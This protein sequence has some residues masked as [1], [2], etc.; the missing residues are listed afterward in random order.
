ME[1]STQHALSLCTLAASLATLYACRQIRSEQLA[2]RTTEDTLDER[3]RRQPGETAADCPAEKGDKN[4]MWWTFISSKED[5]DKVT[6]E[7]A[8]EG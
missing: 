3:E 7:S 6:G 1:I 8:S 5:R 2:R 4:K